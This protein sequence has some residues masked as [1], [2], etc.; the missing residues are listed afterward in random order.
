MSSSGVRIIRPVLRGNVSIPSKNTASYIDSSRG[1]DPR[2][3]RKNVY[4]RRSCY[5]VWYSSE[6]D[7]WDYLL[8]NNIILTQKACLCG[9]PFVSMQ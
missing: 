7:L 8:D 1:N 4:H 5:C 6:C 2:Y 3:C 9:K